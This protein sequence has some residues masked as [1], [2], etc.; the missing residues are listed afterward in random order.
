MPI[1]AD[2]HASGSG[3]IQI[4]VRQVAERAYCQSLE[5]G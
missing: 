3:Q 5:R 1:P 4:G 2:D